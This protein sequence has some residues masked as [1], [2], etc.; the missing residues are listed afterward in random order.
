MVLALWESE[1]AS[2][3]A[4][5]SDILPAESRKPLTSNVTQRRRKVDKI[6][7]REECFHVDERAHGLDVV[8]AQ[9]G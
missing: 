3:L 5:N 4:Y 8:A 7:S 6:Y 1:C 2:I 9:D